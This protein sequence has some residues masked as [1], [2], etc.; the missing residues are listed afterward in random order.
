M[1]ETFY[2]TNRRQRLAASMCPG[3]LLLLMAPPPAVRNNDTHYPY[4]TSS[5]LLYLTGIN[6]DSFAYL[7]TPE[8][9]C[10]IYCLDRDPERERWQG[11][12][13]GR[14]AVAQKLGLPVEAVREYPRFQ[15]ELATHLKNR[16]TL[17]YEFGQNSQAD[18]LILSEINRLN[19]N[20]R[21]GDFGPSALIHVRQV[22][23]E[24]RLVKDE[25]EIGLM[26]Q[27]AQITAKAH[28]ALMRHT[29]AFREG[30]SEA[31][32]KAFL[33]AEF[34]RAGAEALAYPSIV[35]AGGNATILH[36]EKTLGYA[37]PTDLVLVDAG[38]EYHGYAADITRTFPAGGKFSPLQRDLY[39]LVLA[40]QQA[41]IEKTRAGNALHDPHEAA[42]QVLS[43]GLWDLGLLQKYP[44]RMGTSTIWE[45][46]TSL[47]EA[48]EKEYYRQFY[49]HRTSHYLGLD[50]HDVG[51]YYEN[52]ESRKLQGGMVITI[53]PGLYFPPEY[54]HLPE[55]FRGIG[56]RI[57][58]DVLV[59]ESDPDI[60]TRD[61]VKTVAEL[62]A[63]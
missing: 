13:M 41:A 54:D 37:Q 29:R 9:E 47:E 3:S 26:R 57:E 42:V 63:L 49:M 31:E 40:A 33:E 21:K 36:Y 55:E 52:Q 30:V 62:E 59:T 10:T 23:H 61:C 56:I 27:A 25:A 14:E 32:M 20:A 8:G 16:M 43:Q 53:E 22:L 46:P 38:C 44:R 24:Q 18:L 15:R 7:L 1:N 12:V 60:L 34:R 17:Y 19:R 28:N 6:E 4:R 51:A 39:Q 2:Y 35:A 58:D 5:D 48:I 45:F 50:V 11:P